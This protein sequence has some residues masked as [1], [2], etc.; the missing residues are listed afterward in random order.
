MFGFFKRKTQAERLQIQYKNL[1]EEAYKLSHINRA[2]SA[3]K[4]AEAEAV[5]AQ[6]EDLNQNSH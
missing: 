1:L 5:L 2:A 6:I 3:K 4:T